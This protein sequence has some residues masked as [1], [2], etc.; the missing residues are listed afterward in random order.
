MGTQEARDNARAARSHGH[1]STP[2]QTAELRRLV[3]GT[4][5]SA[6]TLLRRVDKAR[7]QASAARQHGWVEVAEA[8]ERLAVDLDALAKRAAR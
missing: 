5:P 8:Y 4:L 1:I 3:R 7:K 6:D 2:D